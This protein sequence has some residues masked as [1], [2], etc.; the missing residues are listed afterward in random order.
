ML[1]SSC[2]FPEITSGQPTPP[3]AS[4]PYFLTLA[5]LIKSILVNIQNSRAFQDSGIF[6]VLK[7]KSDKLKTVQGCTEEAMSI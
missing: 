4:H 1:L 6:T 7:N 5:R 2:Y 3:T